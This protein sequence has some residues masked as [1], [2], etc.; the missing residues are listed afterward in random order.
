MTDFLKPTRKLQNKEKVI[1]IA[2][3]FFCDQGIENSKVS[4]IAARAGLTER[5]V[6]RY[7]ATKSDLVLKRSPNI[8]QF[9]SMQGGRFLR[10]IQQ[11]TKIKMGQGL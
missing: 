1:Q 4:D 11:R 9:S 7:F 5:T 8:G 3:E 2:L 10:E 6:F